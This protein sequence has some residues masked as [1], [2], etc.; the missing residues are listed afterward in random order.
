MLFSFYKHHTR[1]MMEKLYDALQIRNISNYNLPFGYQDNG[2]YVFPELCISATMRCNLKCKLCVVGC[3]RYTVPENPSIDE[4]KEW[5]KRYFDI[6]DFTLKIAVS[7]GEP[8]LQKDLYQ[9]FD[10]LFEYKEYFGRVRIN[11]N[12]TI[13]PND[14]LIKSLKRFGKQAEVLIDKYPSSQ[15]AD[16]VE[17]VLMENDILVLLRDYATPGNYYFNGWVDYGD[18]GARIPVNKECNCRHF[19]LYLRD[20]RLW[21][22]PSQLLYRDF[23]PRTELIDN[24]NIES[25]ELTDKLSI[26]DAREF[27][28]K[29]WSRDYWESCNYCRGRDEN[30]KRYPPAEQ[31][32]KDW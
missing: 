29:Y 11:T 1:Y 23:S 32:N 9:I 30:S 3:P 8:L 15:N 31:Y 18:F 2:E 28:V 16:E 24:G 25:I 20:E 22:C 26:A 10:F 27:L 6:V 12:G 13:I 4:L 19:A 7:G 14:H 17:R 21:M 5:L